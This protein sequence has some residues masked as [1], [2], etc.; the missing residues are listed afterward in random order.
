MMM[1][2]MMMMTEQIFQLCHLLTQ[3]HKKLNPEKKQTQNLTKTNER[4]Q[5]K[6]S[7]NSTKKG[8]LHKD[9]ILEASSVIA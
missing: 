6:R 8:L 3:K 9:N 4:P 1:M 5:K 7:R 2:M